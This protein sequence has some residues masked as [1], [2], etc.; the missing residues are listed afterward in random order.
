MSYI[1]VVPITTTPVCNEVIRLTGFD[2][3]SFELSI[4][5]PLV[6]ITMDFSIS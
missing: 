2:L 6:T 1:P 4:F 3:V 5:D